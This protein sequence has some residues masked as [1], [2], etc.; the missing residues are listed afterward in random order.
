MAWVIEVKE[1]KGIHYDPVTNTL[2]NEKGYEV[3]TIYE[4][5]NGR[6]FISQAMETNFVDEE[7]NVHVGWTGDENHMA[8]HI[9]LESRGGTLK[10]CENRFSD[11]YWLGARDEE[12]SIRIT[13]IEGHIVPYK[14]RRIKRRNVFQRFLDWALSIPIFPEKCLVKNN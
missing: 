5:K 2:K 12:I 13:K 11:E 10:Y 9:E 7:G 1:E 8:A 14:T 4:D 6:L 3:A